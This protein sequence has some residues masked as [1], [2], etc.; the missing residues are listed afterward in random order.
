MVGRSR[1][2]LPLS[3]SLGRKFDALEAELDVRVL[4]SSVALNGSDPRFR[5]VRPVRPRAVD[6][7]AFYALLPFRVAQELRRFG[8]D[9][10]L[11]QGAQETAL[12][13]LG[14]SL[15]RSRAK[16]VADVHGDPRAAT[17]LYGSSL[18]KA[19]SP[20]GRVQSPSAT[21]TSSCVR[22]SQA[23]KLPR[24]EGENRSWPPLLCIL[25]SSTNV[26]ISIYSLTC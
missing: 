22:C 20:L 23:V 19:L 13:L 15:A 4:G 21:A 16:V 11:V 18:R 9:A 10:V 2:S 5:L 12:A 7:A 3:P 6:G 25:L 17:R 8:P 24:S 1:Y 26:G 14:R